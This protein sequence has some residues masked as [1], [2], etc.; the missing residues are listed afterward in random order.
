MHIDS[1]PSIE[2]FEISH[3]Q[4]SEGI[5][6]SNPSLLGFSEINILKYHQKN[7]T[8]STIKESTTKAA[9]K[10]QKTK[11][12]IPPVQFCIEKEFYQ[13]ILHPKCKQWHYNTG[14]G[15][16]IIS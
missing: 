15:Q 6:H 9:I 1:G 8:Q 14:S 11:T 16:N 2:Y 4:S 10:L 7:T 3:A 12:E 13:R 5:N